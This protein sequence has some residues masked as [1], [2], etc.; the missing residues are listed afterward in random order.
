MGRRKKNVNTDEKALNTEVLAQLINFIKNQAIFS[1]PRLRYKK[2]R[3]KREP[4]IGFN[5]LI[6]HKLYVQLRNYV[7]LYA[8]KG[9]SMTEVILAGLEKE[10]RERFAKRTVAGEMMSVNLE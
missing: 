10:L 2:P 6:P 8:E 1:K 4:R 7:N 9:E 3:K 5:L